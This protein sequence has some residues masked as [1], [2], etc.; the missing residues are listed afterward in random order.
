MLHLVLYTRAFIRFSEKAATKSSLN[1]AI[2][3]LF[4][5]PTLL[6]TFVIRRK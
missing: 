4:N 2:Y 5:T 6:L 3:F 1:F